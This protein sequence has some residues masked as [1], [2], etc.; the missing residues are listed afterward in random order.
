[1]AGTGP[2]VE[3]GATVPFGM[4]KPDETNVGPAG[5][6]GPVGPVAPDTPVGPVWFQSSGFS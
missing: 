5:P 1:M 2:R 3:P 4:T 6:V